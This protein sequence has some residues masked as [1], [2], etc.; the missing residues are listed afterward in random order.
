MSLRVHKRLHT[1]L[2]PYPCTEDV[3][4][5]C[6]KHFIS[7]KLLAK[8]VARHNE[9]PALPEPVVEESKVAEEKPV[10]C[11]VKEKEKKKSSRRKNRGKKD[12]IL[13]LISFSGPQFE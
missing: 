2:L 9:V 11:V 8:H 5:P 3:T 4:P 12:D 7:K 13:D 6:G 10:E 1:G